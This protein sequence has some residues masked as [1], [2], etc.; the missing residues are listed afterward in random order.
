MS[1]ERWE[2]V[3]VFDGD[4]Q[5]VGRYTDEQRCRKACLYAQL[6]GRPTEPGDCWDESNYFVRQAVTS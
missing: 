3:E 6:S 2:L 1:A 4:E 5:V